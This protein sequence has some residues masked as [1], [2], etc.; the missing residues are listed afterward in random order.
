MKDKLVFVWW[1]EERAG[2]VEQAQK[3][4]K[5]GAK[6]EFFPVTKDFWPHVITPGPPYTLLLIIKS[7]NWNW[8]AGGSPMQYRELTQ[9]DPEAVLDLVRLRYGL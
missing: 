9:L 3:C 4:I 2:G 6:L 7:D 1:A 5:A 8:T